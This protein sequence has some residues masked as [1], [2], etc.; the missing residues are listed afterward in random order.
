MAVQA[1]YPSNAFRAQNSVF[2]EIQYRENQSANLLRGYCDYAGEQI[3]KN[4]AVF[5]D[6]ESELTCNVS[7]FRKRN[8]DDQMNLTQQNQQQQ[9]SNQFRF[10][11]IPKVP[12]KTGSATISTGLQQS[13][14][15]N[16]LNGSGM[17]STSGRSPFI[18]PLAQD[19]ASCVY[20]QNT[21][22]DTW[23]RFQ[24]EKLRFGLEESRNRHR[25]SLFS[26]LEQEVLK[27]LTVKETELQNMNQ[28]NAELEENVKQM[29]AENQI[30]FTVAKKN[31]AIVSNLRSSLEQIL[32][33]NTAMLKEG[34]GDSSDLGD[35]AQSCCYENVMEKEK[36]IRENQELKDRKTCKVCRENDVSV[37]LFPCRH[38]CLCKDCESKLDLC[39]ICKSLKNATLQIFMS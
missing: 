24:N 29:S 8:R 9:I 37:L 2:E 6:P 39:P 17:T 16:R 13:H 14:D 28:R 18:E 33:H 22:I 23:I 25:R 15:D 1:Q 36:V 30:W 3:L 34:Y 10:V 20:Q 11:N 27:R 38:L 7:G 26:I 12:Q 4:G 21:E 5:S 31:E 32:L 35:D 19:L